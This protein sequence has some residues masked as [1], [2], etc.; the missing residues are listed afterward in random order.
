[1]LIVLKTRQT[2]E[3]QHEPSPSGCTSSRCLLDRIRHLKIT[4]RVVQC[5]SSSADVLLGRVNSSLISTL[6][7]FFLITFDKNNS[8]YRGG[9]DRNVFLSVFLITQLAISFVLLVLP[10][11]LCKQSLGHGRGSWHSSALGVPYS[12]LVPSTFNSSTSTGTH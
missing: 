5:I 11:L 10:S 7:F 1:M 3:E 4:Y 12:L 8:K 6:C 9:I 2:D